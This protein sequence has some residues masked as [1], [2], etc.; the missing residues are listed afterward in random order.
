MTKWLKEKGVT[1]IVAP[2]NG[3][4]PNSMGC[5]VAGFDED[6]MFPFSWTPPYYPDYFAALGYQ[7]THPLWYYEIDFANEK[8]LAA[9]ARYSQYTDAVIRPVSKKNWNRD[10]AIMTD[11]LNETFINEWEF[12]PASHA[13]MQEFMAPMK[14]IVAPEF[15]LI[16]EADGKPVGFCFAVPDLTPLFRSFNGKIGLMAIFKLMTGAAAKFKR[17]GILGIGVAE[18]FRGKGL[19]KAIAMK[20][21]A[22]H[23]SLGLKK[24][25]YFPVN[26]SNT[27]SRG[28]AT[29]IGGTGRLMYQ[30][31]DKVLS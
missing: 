29:S 11:M 7:P 4:A 30:V 18:A 1:T 13:E 20:M 8:Y 15:I 31:Y 21:Y 5:L 6:P 10:I 12:A 2:A 24:S 28:F 14:S 19:A 26:E 27:D 3:G 17:A 22:Y 9:K 16:A 25:F 23:E